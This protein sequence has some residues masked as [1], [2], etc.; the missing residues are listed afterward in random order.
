[1]IRTILTE[2]VTHGLNI[3]QAVESIEHLINAET[4]E[5]LARSHLSNRA[6]A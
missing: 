4:D 2:L 3:D 6:E 5:I 1:V